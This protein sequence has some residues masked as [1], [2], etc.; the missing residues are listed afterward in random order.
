MAATCK[1]MCTVTMNNDV[2]LFGTY[3]YSNCVGFFHSFDAFTLCRLFH[4]NR[5][6]LQHFARAILNVECI[7]SAAAFQIKV[8]L[9]QAMLSKVRS[10][11]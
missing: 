4:S 1:E 5:R 3:Y 8:L 2:I 7:K 6:Q 10:I 11:S 9:Y